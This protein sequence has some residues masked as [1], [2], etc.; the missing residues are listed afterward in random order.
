[1]SKAKKHES[2]PQ[3]LHLVMG[4]EVEK[5]D[6]IV[7]KD[8]ASV[9]LVGVYPNYAAA[10]AVWKQKAQLTVDNAEMRYFVVHMHRLLNPEDDE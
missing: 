4:G 2:K 3:L 9:D 6:D 7:F 8:L 1:M 10:H 5:G